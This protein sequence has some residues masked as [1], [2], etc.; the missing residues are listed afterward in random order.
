MPSQLQRS[1]C[2]AQPLLSADNEKLFKADDKIR[3]KYVDT[4][5]HVHAN[6][7]QCAKYCCSVPFMAIL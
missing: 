7:A 5:T 1:I 2:G 6:C 4:D 3:Y